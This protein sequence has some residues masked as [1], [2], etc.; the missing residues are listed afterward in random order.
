MIIRTTRYPFLSKPI[1]L[2]TKVHVGGDIWPD[3]AV[4]L[5]TDGSRGVGGGGEIWDGAVLVADFF[6]ERKK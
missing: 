1:Q 3:I 2:H 6:N 5:V 4:N